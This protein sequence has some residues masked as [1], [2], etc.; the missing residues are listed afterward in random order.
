MKNKNLILI[1]SK[2]IKET[3]N[4]LYMEWKWN[5]FDIYVKTPRWH[6]A[7]AFVWK[8]WNAY[9][10]DPSFNAKSAIQVENYSAFRRHKETYIWFKD[11]NWKHMWSDNKFVK[12]L[13][14]N[15]KQAN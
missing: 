3:L 8:D 12:Q 7:L 9:V 6:R 14:I 11:I 2:N 13:T 5:V 15:E 1:E 10:I 4:W